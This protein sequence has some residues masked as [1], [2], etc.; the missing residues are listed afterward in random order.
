M[1][2]VRKINGHFR[3]SALKAPNNFLWYKDKMAASLQ[4]IGMVI[5]RTFPFI[6]QRNI[7]AQV[8]WLQI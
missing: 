3:H 8:G 6:L 7:Q 5:C 2:K 1:E 4:R